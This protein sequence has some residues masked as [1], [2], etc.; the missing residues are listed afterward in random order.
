ME[1]LL[2][3]LV[4]IMPVGLLMGFAILAPRWNKVLFL[5]AGMT[6]VTTWSLFEDGRE[7]RLPIMPFVAA[8]QFALMTTCVVIEKEETTFKREGAAEEQAVPAPRAEPSAKE[9]AIENRLDQPLSVNFKAVPLRDGDLVLVVD[10]AL[11]PPVVAQ[12]L[13]RRSAIFG[14]DLARAC[15]GRQSRFATVVRRLAELAVERAKRGHRNARE[16]KDST[17]DGSAA[18]LTGCR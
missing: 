16:S 2:F 1:K 17:R 15:D 13:W 11:A 7:T 12:P 5:I 6:F 9:R 3:V 4:F 10:A 18:G 14:E 8:L